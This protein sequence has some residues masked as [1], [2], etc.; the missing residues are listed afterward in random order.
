[1][2]YMI[3]EA[4]MNQKLNFD[5]SETEREI[6]EYLWENPQ[7][8]LSREMLEYFNEVKKKE[9]KKQTLN[10]FLLRLAEKGLIRGKAQG[11]KKIYQ[12]VYDIKE[13]EAKKAESIL[14]NNYGGSVR[15]FVMALTGGEK[16]DKAMADDLR[17]MLEG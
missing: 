5:V 16:I 4:I 10:T 15:N 2:D 17:K 11:V 7:G 1:M 9:W 14:E 13:Y 12:A 3:T 6:L 8:V